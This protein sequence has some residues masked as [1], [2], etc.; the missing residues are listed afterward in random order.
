MYLSL[1]Q[2]RS[3]ACGSVLGFLVSYRYSLQEIE[4]EHRLLMQRCY[5]SS[6]DRKYLRI[7]Q[8]KTLSIL[9]NTGNSSYS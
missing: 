7:P 9:L 8:F 1:K 5:S 6:K 3:Q 2:K 4:G